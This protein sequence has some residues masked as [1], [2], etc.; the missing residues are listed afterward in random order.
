MW[1][2]KNFPFYEKR[3]KY[4]SREKKLKGI[5]DTAEFLE[6]QSR[7]FPADDRCNPVVI[8]RKKERR[9]LYF[10]VPLGGSPAN[11]LLYKR[12]EQIS[13]ESGLYLEVVPV[14]YVWE[15]RTMVRIELTPDLLNMTAIREPVYCV[16]LDHFRDVMGYLYRW[17]MHVAYVQYP[18]IPMSDLKKY[19]EKGLYPPPVREYEHD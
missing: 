4:P 17:E 5:L 15:R 7:Y 12:L 1:P 3:K 13:R 8:Y 18:G 19:R 11:K 10:K 16:A 2:Y 9:W 6:Y 14:P